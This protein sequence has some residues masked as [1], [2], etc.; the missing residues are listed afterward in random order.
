[1]SGD[2]QQPGERVLFD[3][4]DGGPAVP[5][6][7]PI[8]AAPAAPPAE[9]PIYPPPPTAPVPPPGPLR[10]PPRPAGPGE[11]LPPPA[12]AAIAY[13][14]FGQ[15][16]VAYLIDYVL[17]LLVNAPL[18]LIV[19]GGRA[20]DLSE[21]LDLESQL[22]LAGLSLIVGW[23]YYGYAESSAHQ[24]TPG[25]RLVGLKVCDLEGQRCSFTRASGRYFG[26]ILSSLTLLLGYV[27]CIFTARRQCLHDKAARCLVVRVR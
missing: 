2:E 6:A 9:P 20:N 14:T 7:P 23:L 11:P 10:S 8:S 22:I 12:A 1:M 17:L 3:P 26:M 13:A 21:P 4:P 25:K 18:T 16:V 19:L 24:A 5:I 27:M 15:R